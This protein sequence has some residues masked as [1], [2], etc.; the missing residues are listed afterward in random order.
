MA[1]LLLNIKI[2]TV[3]E[4]G[5]AIAGLRKEITGL[6]RDSKQFNRPSIGGRRGGVGRLGMQARRTGGDLEHAARGMSDLGRSAER[7]LKGPIQAATAYETSLA[8]IRTLTDEAT[9][10]TDDLRRITQESSKEFGGTAA[11]QAGALYDIISAGAKDAAEAQG[12][13]TAAN[14]LAIGGLTDVGNATSAISAVTANFRDENVDSAQAADALFSIVKKGRTTLDQTAR[15]FPKAASA[16]GGI[17]LPLAEAAGAFATL[18]LTTKSSSVAATQFSALIAATAKP[19]IQAEKA[20]ARLNSERRRSGLDEVDITSAGL[21]EKGVA[22][23]AAQ[24]QGVDDNTLA[25]LFGSK[26]ARAAIVA[27]RDNIEGLT[28]AITDAENST[29]AAEKAFATQSKTRAQRLKVLEAN[30]DAAKL[31][32]GEAV[33]P[34][35]DELTPSLVGVAEVA[36]S[37]AREHPG[38]VKAGGALAIAAVGFGKVGEGIVGVTR[39]MGALRNMAAIA[40]PA[41]SKLAGLVG[42]TGKL[43][44]I[45]AVGALS[46]A[47]GTFIDHQLGISDA[48]AAKLAGTGD[49]KRVAEQGAVGFLSD[50]A[51]IK[52]DAGNVITDPRQRAA[53]AAQRRGQLLRS[54]TVKGDLNAALFS[55]GFTAKDVDSSLGIG[56]SRSRRTGNVDSVGPGDVD[57]PPGRLDVNIKVASDGTATVTGVQQSNFEGE[58]D[59]SAGEGVAI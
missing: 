2:R 28:A 56:P 7:L 18:T 25:K 39:T 3:R 53:L 19:T 12:T 27:F 26:Q 17:K 41:V 37:L 51:L 8:D 34:I 16:A 58:V 49:E 4:G 47:L 21:R 6:A 33:A 22:G 43:G 11:D 55:Q 13:L 24:F 54:G 5:T 45:G 15:A 52:D 23:F 35:V 9:F 44:M 40:G 57:R 50:K 30:L 20:L 32:I 1:D 10:S 48:I 14:K 31:A 46:F 42:G 29:G 59:A 36:A 38:I